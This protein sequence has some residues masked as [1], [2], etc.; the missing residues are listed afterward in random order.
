MSGIYEEGVGER[1][2]MVCLYSNNSELIIVYLQGRGL[3]STGVGR[4]TVYQS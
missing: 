1:G 3:Q 2:F 4:D